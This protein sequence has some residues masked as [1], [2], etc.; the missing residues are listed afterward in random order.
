MP[1]APAC[2]CSGGRVLAWDTRRAAAAVGPAITASITAI[3]GKAL[4]EAQ[5]PVPQLALSG[6]LS[7]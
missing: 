7:G 6:G 2:C 3:G 4:R 1:A 5:A